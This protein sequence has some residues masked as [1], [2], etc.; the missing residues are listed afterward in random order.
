MCCVFGGLVVGLVVWGR[1]LFPVADRI[2]ISS[3]VWWMKY[4][5]M[6]LFKRGLLGLLSVEGGGG[7]VWFSLSGLTHFVCR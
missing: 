6:D 7:C 5:C 3:C 1:S 2:R 4:L